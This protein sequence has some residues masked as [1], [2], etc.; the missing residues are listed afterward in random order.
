M[1]SSNSEVKEEQTCNCCQRPS[2]PRKPIWSVTLD[3]DDPEDMLDARHSYDPT[4]GII[5]AVGVDGRP[6][7]A[8]ESDKWHIKHSEVPEYLMNLVDA[9]SSR[10]DW[11]MSAWSF[12][13]NAISVRVTAVV[14]Q[15]WR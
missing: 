5:I 13:N 4:D 8:L 10:E 14:D 15:W 6:R 7:L 12:A 9:L 11:K 1:R 3:G 2:K